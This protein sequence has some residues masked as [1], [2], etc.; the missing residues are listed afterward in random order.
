MCLGLAGVS[1]LYL[2]CYKKAQELVAPTDI[3]FN[4][5]AQVQVFNATPGSRGNYVYVDGAAVTGAPFS[6]AATFPSTPSN[7]AVTAGFRFFLI[8]DTFNIPT[9][10]T[11]PPMSFGEVLQSSSYYTIFTYDTLNSI[12]QKIVT[13]SI[14]IP[15]DTTCRIRFANFI[16]SSLAVPAVDVWSSRRQANIFTNVSVTEVTGYIPYDSRNTDTLTIRVAGSG[17]DLLN[18]T[19]SGTPPVTTFPPVRI[20]I[21]PTRLRSYTLVF[22]GSW[23]ADLTSAATVRGL[24]FFSNN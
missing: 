10:T 13:N 14:S 19:I 3:S 7:F 22:R 18:R 1:L 2:S 24:S 15:T 23:R 6:Y 4:N 11:Q 5:K 20:F 16:Y 9:P 21:T 8:R 17:T 12:K